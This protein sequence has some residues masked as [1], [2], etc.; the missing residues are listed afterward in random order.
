MGDEYSDS[1]SKHFKRG[2]SSLTIE[3]ERENGGSNDGRCQDGY[4][5]DRYSESYRDENT[6]H[7]RRHY[8]RRL[9]RRDERSRTKSS[10]AL[11]SSSSSGRHRSDDRERPSRSDPQD[12][13]SGRVSRSVAVHGI[14]KQ[15]DAGLVWNL[16]QHCQA[17]DKMLDSVEPGPEKVGPAY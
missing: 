12:G 14:Q 2:R 9:D 13:A 8:E 7:G 11:S 15:D 4:Y 3:A 16:L 17:D 6:E 1:R 5:H 10:S